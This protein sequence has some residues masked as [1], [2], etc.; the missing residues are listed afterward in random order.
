M[1]QAPLDRQCGS[2]VRAAGTKPDPTKGAVGA[3]GGA[4]VGWA[5]GGPAGAL[6]GG[7]LGLLAGAAVGANDR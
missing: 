2:F 1:L 5:I 6:V 7:I 3:A 4:L